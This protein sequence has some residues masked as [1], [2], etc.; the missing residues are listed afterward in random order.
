MSSSK[1][2]NNAVLAVSSGC[3]FWLRA[4]CG[5][6]RRMGRRTGSWCLVPGLADVEPAHGDQ[7]EPEVAHFGQH[8]VQRGLVSEQ[9]ADERLLALA[10]DL[11]AVE[12][13]GPPAVQD[14]R[15]ADLISGRV[16]GGAPCRLCFLHLWTVGADARAG[17]HPKVAC[18]WNL[19]VLA[20]PH[21]PEWARQRESVSLASG[22]LL[23][24][25]W[26]DDDSQP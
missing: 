14:T 20:A 9:A 23:V 19:A 16:A 18:E 24:A 7:A 11:E 3:E 4:R 21:G 5:G 25:G 22:N 12:P 15:H 13:G 6:R 1:F 17:R 8:P 10:A 26:S 2:A